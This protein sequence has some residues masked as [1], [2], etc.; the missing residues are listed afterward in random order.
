[1][2]DSLLDGSVPFLLQMA[3]RFRLFEREALSAGHRTVRQTIVAVSANKPDSGDTP[4]DLFDFVCS[5]PLSREDLT[6]LVLHRLA[7][8][9]ADATHNV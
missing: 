8:M 3:R 6:R 2:R 7:P 1:M 4:D 5:K 9:A